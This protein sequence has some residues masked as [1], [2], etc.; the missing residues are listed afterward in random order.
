MSLSAPRATLR[1]TSRAALLALIA[2]PL[3]PAVSF[4]QSRLDPVVVIGTREAQALSK[5]VADIVLIDSDT[6]RD[7]GAGSVQD[8]LRRYAGVQFTQNG[9]PGQTAGY[10]LRGTSTSGTIVMVDGVR[11]GSA[12]LGQAAFESMSL[13]TIDHI[14]VLRGPASGLYGADAVGGVI[15][16]FTKK[17][18]G[19]LNVTA[20]VA[21]GEYNSRLGDIGIS[22]AQAGFDY[23]AS[24]SR[25]T[26][27]GMTA[28]RADSGSS[29]F[30]PDRDGFARTVGTVRLGF[31]PAEGH[32]VGVS[33][34]QGRLNAQYDSA[35]FGGPPNYIADPSGDFRNRL[36]TRELT[37]DY[38]GTL[39][40]IWTTTVQ[41]GRGTDDSVSGLAD[42]PRFKTTR[43]QITWQNALR[44]APDQ[45][46]VLAYEHL[47]EK[48][49]GV[50]VGALDRNTNSYIAGYSGQFGP[51]AVEAS[52]RHD[53]NSAYGKNTSGTIGGSYA[54]SSTLKLRALAGKSFRAPTFNDTS[55]PF[56]GVPT[57]KPETGRS[58][59]LGVNWQSGATSASATVYR[60]K[61]DNLIG[62]NPDPTG[63]ECPSGYFGCAYNISKAKLQGATLTGAH[64]I[65]NLSVSA[66][67][68]FLDAKD[69]K[70]GTR[71]I[72]RAAHQESVSADYDT[73]VWSVGAS[74]TDVG[75]RP[76]SAGNL[77][78]YAL[79]DLRATWRFLPQWR[80]E[81]K[82]LNAADRDVQPVYTYQ[83]LGRQAW[84]GV[85]Y[86]MKGF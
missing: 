61:L 82:V 32:R 85:R 12:S 51:A 59:E 17:G 9:G 24:L 56:Y 8:V 16:I 10:L 78:A 3:L 72:R 49:E 29:S 63:K 73:G 21:V 53:D 2:A 5:S 74:L 33:A 23:A 80:L 38:R 4:A 15:Q 60:N 25:E 30:N 62:Y 28:I 67:V 54:L 36:K 27:D 41:L 14:E 46:V 75:K 79:L 65:G 43:D 57:I 7:S 69:E 37:A 26:S 86:D 11:V 58:I 40:P 64:R 13:S 31:T 76:D 1:A 35:V 77:G 39:S 22:G 42:A 81:A 52:V 6:L 18:Q 70:T 68:D 55:Y 47:K 34:T 48:A 19:P 45:Q 66:T 71:L 50:T 20:G 83:G 84:V 44:I